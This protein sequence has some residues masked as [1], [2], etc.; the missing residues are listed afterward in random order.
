MYCCLFW[1][2]LQEAHWHPYKY[3]I[4]I[5]I[6]SSEIFGWHK[7]KKFK[8]SEQ[9]V[10]VSATEDV[11]LKVRTEKCLKSKKKAVDKDSNER[12]AL[13]VSVSKGYQKV[14]KIQRGDL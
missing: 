3:K 14:Y 6:V 1:F 11:N 2:K 10:P 13:S 4:R 12:Q 5:Q 9:I 8:Y 7:S